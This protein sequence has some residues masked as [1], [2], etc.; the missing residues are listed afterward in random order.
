MFGKC[1]QGYEGALC[2]QCQEGYYQRIDAFV[3]YSCFSIWWEV[4]IWILSIAVCIGI[5]YWIQKQYMRN[6]EAANNITLTIF[7]IMVTNMQMIMM[8]SKIGD[9][10]DS[11]VEEIF[12]SIKLII[13]ELFLRIICP[14]CLLKSIDRETI[15][16]I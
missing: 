8:L 13:L 14:E 4:I 1:A 11:R 9:F 10:G 7:K 15:F 3:C 5:I 12:L 6:F 16:Y 2:G